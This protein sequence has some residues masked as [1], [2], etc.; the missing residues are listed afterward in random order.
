[1][2]SSIEVLSELI[3][4]SQALARDDRQLVIL[5]EGNTSADCGDGTFW[6]K[7]SGSQL[8]NIAETGFSR[9]RLAAIQALLSAEQLDDTQVAD[10]LRDALV[11]PAHRQPSVETFLHALCLT[12]GEARWV[13]HTHPVSVN[14]ILCSALGAEPF[15][16]HLFP[17]AV[18]VCGLAPAVVPYIDPGIVLAAA[19]RAELRAHKERFGQP[20]KVLLMANHGVVALG[21]SS[22]EVLNISLM[23]D[24]WARVLWGTYALGGPQFMPQQEVERIDSRMDEHYRR[25]RLDESA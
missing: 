20:P 16:G 15:R 6:V 4:L 21:Q 8:G 2:G 22:Q 9:V 14:R 25:R 12:E 13:G 7:A 1:M 10:G 11:D 17:D 23:M 19:V 24:K 3:R 5:S 18:V